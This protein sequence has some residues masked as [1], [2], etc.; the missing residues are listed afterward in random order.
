MSLVTAL[1]LAGTRPE[2]DPFAATFGVRAKALIPVAGE[3]MLLRP[4]RALL[5]SPQVSEVAVLAQQPEQLAGIL[6]DHP[7]LSVQRSLGTIA[8]TLS[9]VCNDPATRW[10]VLVTTADHALLTP[11]MIAEF[12]AAAQGADIAV[13]F[14]ESTGLLARFPDA[15]RTWLAFG[16]GRY[17]GANLFFLGTPGAERA[18]AQWRSVES[19]R[20][21]GLRVLAALGPAL[22]MGAVLKLRSLHQT[23]DALGRKLGI[24]I[25]AVEMSDPLAAIDV[26]KPSD[27]ALVESIIRDSA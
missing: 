22:F 2:G 14:V 15:Q 8:D 13:A 7:E 27:H 4:V 20:K 1:V 16:G 9:G 6:P 23:A 5:A 10:P 26:D 11:A 18:I 24:I 19:D 17:S 25:R 21:K 12:I 3:P